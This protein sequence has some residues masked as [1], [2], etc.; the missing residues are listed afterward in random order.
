MHCLILILLPRRPQS[1]SLQFL[2]LIFLIVDR[3]FTSWDFICFGL[4]LFFHIATIRFSIA[5][6]F[7]VSYTLILLIFEFSLLRLSKTI[8]E[9]RKLLLV[10]GLDWRTWTK[11]WKCF[12]FCNHRPTCQI[13]LWSFILDRRSFIC[14]K[15]NRWRTFELV[16]Q[17]VSQTIS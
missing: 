2:S 16:I 8:S 10:L 7:L 13:A 11:C 4:I 15:V 9:L 5:L 1:I 14:T 12:A 6:L 3:C 17:V